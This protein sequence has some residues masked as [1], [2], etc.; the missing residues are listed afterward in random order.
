MILLS[1]KVHASSWFWKQKLKTQLWCHAVFL[2][3]RAERRVGVHGN[4][5]MKVLFDSG[6]NIQSFFLFTVSP[7]QSQILSQ[8]VLKKSCWCMKPSLLFLLRKYLEFNN[9]AAGK[10]HLIFFWFWV[11]SHCYPL[12]I[13]RLKLH[14]CINRI[15]ISAVRIW[16]KC[17]LQLCDLLCSLSW[18]FSELFALFCSFFAQSSFTSYVSPPL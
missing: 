16:L 12:S 14:L 13:M 9:G 17:E 8:L 1:L 5:W 4:L 3:A 11:L 6:G 2:C 18:V 10:Q 7:S 15:S